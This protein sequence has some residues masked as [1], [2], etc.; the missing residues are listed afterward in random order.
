M[1]GTVEEGTKIEEDITGQR[2]EA[3][4]CTSTWIALHMADQ[5]E[6]FTEEFG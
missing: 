1:E 6:S 4:L 5:F 3:N 2:M